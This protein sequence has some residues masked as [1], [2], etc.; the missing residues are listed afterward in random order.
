MTGVQTCAL[1]IYFFDGTP[2]HAGGP[3]D[4]A[5]I[6]PDG[7][8]LS[9]DAWHDPDARTLGM[10]LAGESH[11]PGEDGV[12][13]R[14]ESFLVLLHSGTEEASFTL[15]GQP[16]GSAYRLIVDTA[17]GQAEESD[18]ETSAGA[19]IAMAPR[20]MLVLHALR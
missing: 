2:L 13:I 9:S 16:Y 15:P 1:P 12:P 3:K 20:S 17:S 5:W 19:T 7:S 14:D 11:G 8:E 18:V 10:F 4:L 6:G